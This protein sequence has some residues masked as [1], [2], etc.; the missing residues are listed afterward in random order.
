LFNVD[1]ESIFT[2]LKRRGIE[3]AVVEYGNRGNA[4]YGENVRSCISAES[5]EEVV[6]GILEAVQTDHGFIWSRMKDVENAAK[7][8]DDE[9]V[10]VAEEELQHAL[11]KFD[12][13][14]QRLWEG[15][16]PCTAL[17][18]I[19]GSGDPREMSRLFAK[20]KTYEAELRVKQY[21]DCQVKWMDDD[22]QAY[23]LAVDK[24]RTGLG[25]ITVK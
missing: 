14:L 3:S 22:Q 19:T 2:R 8:K 13:N 11:S 4:F 6:D 16:P 9:S 23:T 5:D 24:A 21:D 12:A 20:K 15:L 25:F 17:M 18:V 10:N 1:Q 7:W